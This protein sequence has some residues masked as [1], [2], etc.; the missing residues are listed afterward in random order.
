MIAKL[1]SGRVKNL[2][3]RTLSRWATALGGQLRMAVEV[4]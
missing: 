3:L 2:E 1:E 4:R